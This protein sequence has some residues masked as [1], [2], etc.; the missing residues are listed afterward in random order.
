MAPKQLSARHSP[1]A[2]A[3]ASGKEYPVIATRDVVVFPKMTASVVFKNPRSHMAI[4][5]ALGQNRLAVLL[6]RKEKIGPSPE[7]GN[8]YSVGTLVKILESHKIGDRAIILI[9]EGKARVIIEKFIKLDPYFEARVKEISEVNKL[10]I[11]GEAFMYNIEEH[12]KKCVALGMPIPMETLSIVFSRPLPSEKLDLIAF[13]LELRP[14][15]KQQILETFNLK[16]RLKIINEFIGRKLEVLQVAKKIEQ[17]TVKELGKMQREAILHEQLKAIQKELGMGEQAD[18]RELRKKIKEVRMPAEN[19]KIAKKELDRLASLPSFSPEISYIRAYLDW[20]TSLP[21][22]KKSETKLNIARSR[23][24]LDEDHYGLEDVK[25]RMLEYIAV[26]KLAK[27]IKGPI[28]CFVGP[29]GTGKTSVG[30]S[31]ARALGRKFVRMSLGG[32]RDEA[33]IR[34]HRRTYV[35]ALPGRIIQGVKTAGTKNPV[36]MLDEIDKVG[37][38]FRGD[39]S[40]ALLEALDPEQNYAFSDHYI[41]IPFDLSD[42][43]FIT[44]AN[45]LDPVP[46]ALKDRMEV[47]EFPG[48]TE[49]EKFHIARKFLIPKLIASHGLSD[50]KFKITDEAIRDIIRG[51]TREAGV[52]ELEREL[53]RICRRVARKI[54]EKASEAKKL[55]VI[56]PKDLH[57]YLGPI[58]FRLVLAEKKD[59]VGVATGLAWTQVGGEIL[60]IEAT[61]MPGKGRLI[62]TGHLGEVMKE[63]AQAAF[64][65]IRS[66]AQKLGIKKDFYKNLDLHVHVPAGAIPK[67]GPSAGIAMAVTLTSCLAARPTRREIGMTGEVTL[68]G[69]VLEI[70]GVKEK[71]LAAHRAGLKKVILPWD[72]KKDLE[73]IPAKVTKDLKLLFVKDM[74]EVLK[75][76]LKK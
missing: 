32:I 75:I 11:E 61:K 24:I 55:Q 33:E 39:P 25:K 63:S 40:A 12:F 60:F 50:H 21:W 6:L 64:S 42:V 58:K 43:M 44:T 31:I 19:E 65:Y 13:S 9:V 73:K 59:E 28:L 17:K 34:G 22:S 69:K 70:G 20:L 41:E 46:P 29:P 10:T 5:R 37:A 38:D 74:D 56:G 53:A 57:A 71:V 27:K 30:K 18:I 48:Y 26:C 14:A 4:R 15:Q 51:Y 66:R 52:R 47:V 7:P 36:F 45:I 72:N 3:L 54:T 16:E 35:G 1:E 76:A 8:L 62:L 49:E 68:R 2:G 23:K 67:D